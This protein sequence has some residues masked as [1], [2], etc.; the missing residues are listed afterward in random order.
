[1]TDDID[2]A[3]APLDAVA[4]TDFK[5]S[6]RDPV[7]DEAAL[8]ERF[9]GSWAG[10]SESEWIEPGAA[11]S[12][13]GGPEWSLLDH[14]G[15]CAWWQEIGADYTER[16]LAGG[17]WPVDDDFGGGDMDAF[18][19]SQRAEWA[20]LASSV[21]VDR[22]EASHARLLALVRRAP[23]DVVE[24][25]AWSDWV[26]SLLRPHVLDHLRIIEPWAA[27]LRARRGGAGG[28]F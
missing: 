11:P 6:G 25:E 4:A 23:R 17:R 28:S 2:L 3:A 15:H 22:L 5:A 18:N 16:I 13:A 19:E 21:V 1:V 12:D 27:T 14:V 26:T 8:W 10:L 20:G 24:N 9:T 7:A